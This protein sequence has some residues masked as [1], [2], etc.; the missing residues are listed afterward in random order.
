MHRE[1]ESSSSIG[2][3]VNRPPD[4]NTVRKCLDDES[5]F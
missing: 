1:S 3:G 4:V 2:F 5:I